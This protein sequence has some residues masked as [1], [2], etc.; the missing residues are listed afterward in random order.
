TTASTAAHYKNDDVRWNL[1]WVHDWQGLVNQVML[2][3]QNTTSN[4]NASPSPQFDYFYYPIAGNTSV[5][6]PIINVGGPGA[7]VGFRDV[8]PGYGIQDDLTLSNIHDH[9]MKVGPR[10]QSIDL[11][12]AARTLHL[13][14]AVEFGA[15][16]CAGFYA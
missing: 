2:T 16:S 5:T 10:F 13:R 7:G 4:T 3:H 15:V 1:R 9:T 12:S 11:I 6:Q 8:Q 14:D